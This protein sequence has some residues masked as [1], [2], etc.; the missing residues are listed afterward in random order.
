M[1][2]DV[3]LILTNGLTRYQVE[4]L[5]RTP[6]DY[7]KGYRL[8]GPDGEPVLAHELPSGMQECSCVTWTQARSCEHTTLLTVAGLFDE[9]VDLYRNAFEDDLIDTDWESDAP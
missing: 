8:T 7:R 1:I 4:R 6:G 5:P 3:T 9:P 2:G